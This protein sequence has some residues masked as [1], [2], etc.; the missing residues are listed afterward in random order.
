MNYKKTLFFL[1]LSLLCSFVILNSSFAGSVDQSQINQFVPNTPAKASEVNSNFETLRQAIND[2]DVKTNQANNDIN[3]LNSNINGLSSDISGLTSHLNNL[4]SDIDGLS[5]D[6]DGLSSNINGL[7]SDIDGLSSDISGLTSHLNNLDSDI[8]GLNSDIDGLNSDINDLN[9]D[10]NNHKSYPDAH[11]SRYTDA[12]AVNAA[13][14][15]GIGEVTNNSIS[16]T[17]TSSFMEQNIPIP[18]GDPVG[19]TSTITIPDI[20]IINSIN[21]NVEI[22]TSDISTLDIKLID[23]NNNIYILYESNDWATGTILTGSWPDPNAILDGDISIWIDKNPMGDWKL[24]VIDNKDDSLQDDG[25]ITDWG[26]TL[27]GVSSDTVTIN[28]DL[29]VNGSIRANGGG[30]IITPTKML[31]SRVHNTIFFTAADGT[32]HTL[33]VSDQ[34]QPTGNTHIYYYPNCTD[35]NCRSGSGNSESVLYMNIDDSQSICCTLFSNEE[36]H[37]SVSKGLYWA[38]DGGNNS[39]DAWGNSTTSTFKL[40]RDGVSEAIPMANFSSYAIICF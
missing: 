6:I 33:D 38:T 17:F 19:A 23:P 11:H 25:E 1:L 37:S 12:E 13:K 40:S 29:K 30:A 4:D 31:L 8:D 35:N 36:D 10:I 20:G 3:N 18:D 5:S 14:E 7:S 9:I 39:S 2:N 22:N 21:I 34:T 16:T 24:W 28:G 15:A 26:I 27:K 32:Q